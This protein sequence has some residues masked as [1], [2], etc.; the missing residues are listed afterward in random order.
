M[1]ARR[2]GLRDIYDSAAAE[3][4]AP[5]TR[6]RD[7]GRIYAYGSDT[8][9]FSDAQSSSKATNRLR[10]MRDAKRQ[11]ATA[12]SSTGR[13]GDSGGYDAANSRG[14]DSFGSKGA[15]SMDRRNN[16]VSGYADGMSDMGRSSERGGREMGGPEQR[17]ARPRVGLPTHPRG[18]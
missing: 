3:A 16:Y 2:R 7:D 4:S 11:A 1:N 8:S 5:I 10:A 14:G 12:A 13:V 18:R 9:S 17:M 15:M 6:T